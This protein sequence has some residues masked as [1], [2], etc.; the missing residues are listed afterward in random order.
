LPNY[1]RCS[2]STQ[3]ICIDDELTCDKYD[4]CPNGSDEEPCESQNETN[5][6]YDKFTV[7]IVSALLIVFIIFSIVLLCYCKSN[8]RFSKLLDAIFGKSFKMKHC[9]GFKLFEL[10]YK[11]GQSTSDARVYL[12]DDMDQKQNEDLLRSI[13]FRLFCSFFSLN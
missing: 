4:H 7:T 3:S 5:L 9:W 1:H 6:S 2:N 10:K 12:V 13:Y 8:K 11:G